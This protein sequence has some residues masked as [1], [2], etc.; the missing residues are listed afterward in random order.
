MKPRIFIGSSVEGINIAKA[1]QS[2]L[3]HT[4]EVTVWDQGIFNLSGNA[5]SDLISLTKNIDFGIMIFSPDDEI[6]M[7]AETSKVVRDN[8]IFELGL[9]MGALGQEKVFYLLPRGVDMHI[10]TD[11]IGITPGT[12]EPNRTDGNLNAAVGTFC[13][14]VMSQVNKIGPEKTFNEIF[15]LMEKINPVINANIKNGHINLSINISTKNQTKLHLIEEKS[16]HSD[17]INFTS[18]GN[19]LS[20]N[21]NSNGGIN[22]NYNGQ[23][24]GFNFQFS[25]EYIKRL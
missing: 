23:Q 9:F 20:N 14:Q 22:D 16:N 2:A 12:F 18:N 1:V 3:E 6:N 19:F 4:A 13:T 21:T 5:L 10:P 15:E 25:P 24:N 17:F 8:V 11:L 7:R